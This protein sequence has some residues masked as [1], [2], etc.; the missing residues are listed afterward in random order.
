MKEESRE[1]LRNSNKSGKTSSV[2]V[3]YVMY[4]EGMLVNQYEEAVHEFWEYE[5]NL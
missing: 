5:R 1:I 4:Q 2:Y 3:K